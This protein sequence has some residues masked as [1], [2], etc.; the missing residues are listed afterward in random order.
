MTLILAI[1]IAATQAISLPPYW[2][3]E[4]S[5]TW[6]HVGRDHIANETSWKEDDPAGYKDAVWGTSSLV[7]IEDGDF[8]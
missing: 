1:F 4:Y 6:F 8:T 3:G 7:Q 5:N 2:D